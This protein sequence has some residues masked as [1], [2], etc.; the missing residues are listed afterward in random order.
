MHVHTAEGYYLGSLD[1]CL[2]VSTLTKCS[3]TLT[4]HV[5]MLQNKDTPLVSPN[6][7]VGTKM[8][9]YKLVSPKLVTAV[10]HGS[11]P[12]PQK[13]IKTADTDLPSAFLWHGP[14]P[15]SSDPGTQSGI[16]RGPICEIL[17]LMYW[18][19]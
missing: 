4:T 2:S 10:C 18:I 3:V 14:H 16:S 19:W 15:G 13:A 11:S 8:L 17:Q 6:Q 1:R 7:V 9:S 12:H 5:E